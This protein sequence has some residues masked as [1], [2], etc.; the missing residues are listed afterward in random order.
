MVGSLIT[1]VTMM[2]GR[3]R[4]DFTSEHNSSLHIPKQSLCH[5]IKFS[6][7]PNANLVYSSCLLQVFLSFS[8]LI[9]KE[10]FFSQTY[11]QK[12]EMN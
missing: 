10:V 5:A 6:L 2:A 12:S 3:V 8:Y 7:S 4:S 9:N 11:P 1:S